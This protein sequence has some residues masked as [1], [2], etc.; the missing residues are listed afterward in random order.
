MSSKKQSSRKK[1]RKKLTDAK[2]P[3]KRSKY[4][5]EEFTEISEKSSLLVEEIK[6]EDE[7][8]GRKLDIEGERTPC[9]KS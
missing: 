5:Q 9:F 3:T 2:P 4:S 1:L 7:D 8:R 6:E